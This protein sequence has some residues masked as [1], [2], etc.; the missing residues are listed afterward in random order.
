MSFNR[1]QLERLGARFPAAELAP[2]LAR[3]DYKPDRQRRCI[4]SRVNGY[5]LH[6]FY[7]RG[8]TLADIVKELESGGQIVRT[9]RK[10]K[11]HALTV[12]AIKKQMK[13]Q[14]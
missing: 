12:A 4:V 6:G 7:P 3:R 5:T 9:A 1:E 2:V 14:T 11:A 8:T 13:D 10:F